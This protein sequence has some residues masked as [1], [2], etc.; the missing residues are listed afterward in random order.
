M[1]EWGIKKAVCQPDPEK[2]NLQ[3]AVTVTIQS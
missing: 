1:G 2:V 3:A